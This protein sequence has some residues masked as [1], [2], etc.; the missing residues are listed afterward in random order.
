MVVEEGGGEDGL[1]T[2]G[3]DFKTL[4]PYLPLLS[5]HP[6]FV[7]SLRFSSTNEQ[8]HMGYPSMSKSNI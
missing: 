3:E 8:T 6:S 4:G 7:K 1:P 5:S 2:P